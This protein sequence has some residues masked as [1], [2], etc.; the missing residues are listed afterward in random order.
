[1]PLS[2]LAKSPPTRFSIIFTIFILKSIFSCKNIFKIF[3]TFKFLKNFR[4]FKKFLER[5]EKISFYRE[6]MLEE[7]EIF[8]PVAFRFSRVF[9][10]YLFSWE[11]STNVTIKVYIALI[12]F[13]FSRYR[14]YLRGNKESLF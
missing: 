7:N 3:H 11:S 2:H 1:M 9:Y 10:Q 6:K 8:L 14:M 12:K 13:I 4:I 5:R